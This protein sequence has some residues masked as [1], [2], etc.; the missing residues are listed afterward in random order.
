MVRLKRYARKSTQT[1]PEK[2]KQDKKGRKPVKMMIK[3]EF[4]KTASRKAEVE[5]KNFI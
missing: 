3:R 5:I 1:W 4:F 2:Y